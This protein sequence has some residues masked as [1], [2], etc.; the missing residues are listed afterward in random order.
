LGTEAS[1]ETL[2]IND[3][4]STTTS[5]NKVKQFNYGASLI[6]LYNPF[7]GLQLSS[8]FEYLFVNQ[9]TETSSGQ[10]STTDFNFPALYIGAAYRMRN[11]S[12]G[13]R[14]D[15]LYNENK[16]IY[17]NALSPFVRVFF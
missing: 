4:F 10:K 14:Y 13:L 16:S 7:N 6:G 11:I 15:L 5:T 3:D 12:A 17:G 1:Q 9:N 8:E 2:S